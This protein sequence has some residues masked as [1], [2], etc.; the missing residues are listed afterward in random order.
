MSPKNGHPEQTS[1]LKCGQPEQNRKESL[2]NFIGKSAVQWSVMLTL[3]TGLDLKKSLL[4][5][6]NFGYESDSDSEGR[7]VPD[8]SSIFSNPYRW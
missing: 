8:M 1:V 4:Q 2:S 3:E 6:D 5:M 7:E